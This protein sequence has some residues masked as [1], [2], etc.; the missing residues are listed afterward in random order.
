M[1]GATDAEAAA[2]PRAHARNVA[3]GEYDA[4]AA[5]RLTPGNDVEQ[6]GLARPVRSPDADD[7]AFFDFEVEPVD[8]D[9]TAEGA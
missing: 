1:V 9:E 7:L 4:T 6:R 8:D 3:A 2:V 5:G